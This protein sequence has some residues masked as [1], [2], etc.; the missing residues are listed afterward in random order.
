[1]LPI[2]L[3]FLLEFNVWLGIEPTL[4]LADWM[5]FATILPLVFGA[6]FQTPLVMLLLERI[7]VFTVEDYRAKRRM[8]ILIMVIAAAILTPTQDPFSMCLLAVPMIILYELG[9]WLVG[10]TRTRSDEKAAER[11]RQRTD[12]TPRTGSSDQDEARCPVRHDGA[13]HRRS[14][15]DRLSRGRGAG[16]SRPAHPAR[17]G[18]PRAGRRGRL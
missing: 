2:T 16:R 5:S 12:S 4:R 8:A 6:C 10:R 11:G 7:G 13:F 3:S 15:G 17:R 9:I 14:T 18:S 1:M